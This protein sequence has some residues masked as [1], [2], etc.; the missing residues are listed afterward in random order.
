[1][2][3][4]FLGGAVLLIL[5]FQGRL[6]RYLLVFATECSCQVP[7]YNA[8]YPVRIYEEMDEEI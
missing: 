1:M 6:G 4:E 2:K 5:D 7:E 8:L 3:I